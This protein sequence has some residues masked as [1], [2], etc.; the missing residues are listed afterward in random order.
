[1]LLDSLEFKT[2]EDKVL[3]KVARDLYKEYAYNNCLM[4]NTKCYKNR[5]IDCSHS[6]LMLMQVKKFAIL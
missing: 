6:L 1:M 3:E 2:L 4:L 5:N